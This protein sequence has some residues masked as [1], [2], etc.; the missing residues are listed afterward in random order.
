MIIVFV[1]DHEFKCVLIYLNIYAVIKT[2]KICL[3]SLA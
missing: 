1:R 3:V 2:N